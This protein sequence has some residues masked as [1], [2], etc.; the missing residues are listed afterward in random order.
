MFV[1]PAPKYS[2]RSFSLIPL[3][4]EGILKIFNFETHPKNVSFPALHDILKFNFS[5]N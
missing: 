1:D 4:V 5:Q 3:S 2:P